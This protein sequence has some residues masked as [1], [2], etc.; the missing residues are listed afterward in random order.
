[1]AVAITIIGETPDF[2]VFEKPPDLLIHPTK[3]D[4]PKTALDYLREILCFEIANGATPGI[5]TRLD[6]E[7]SGLVLVAKTRDCARALVALTKQRRIHKEYL[8]LCFG[9]PPE[10]LFQVD[11]PLLRL[12]EVEP[13]R[14]WLKRGVH[15]DGAQAQ[16]QFKVL[17]RYE[18]A[19]DGGSFSLLRVVPKTG[20]THQIRV[21]AALAGF[22]LLGDKLYAKGDGWYLRFIEEGWTQEM[23][24]A[25]W[26]P[27]HALHA[28]ALSWSTDDGR[29]F[30]FQSALPPDLKAFVQQ[31]S[32]ASE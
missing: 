11:A 12:G 7:T 5:I 28:A 3:P 18:R 14:V 1:M 27:R 31:E 22:P 19:S 21:H 9:W 32:K 13:F 15:P 8:A 6:R 17:Q 25:L 10:D 23:E 2:L 4:S 16:T 20:R 29:E 30:R 26:L 24:Q